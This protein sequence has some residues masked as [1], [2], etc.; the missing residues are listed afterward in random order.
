MGKVQRREISDKCFRKCNSE[1]GRELGLFQ[2]RKAGWD[3][4]LKYNTHFVAKR[5]K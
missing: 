4:V 1:R 3:T 5:K 2:I